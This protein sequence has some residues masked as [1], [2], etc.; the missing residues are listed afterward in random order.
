VTFSVVGPSVSLSCC[1]V[2]VKR[3]AGRNGA[4]VAVTILG[5]IVTSTSL[6]GIPV[7]AAAARALASNGA[8]A[9]VV[10]WE[11]R[12]A[13]M[14]V[15]G[16]NGTVERQPE[17]GGQLRRNADGAGRTGVG[18]M[19]LDGVGHRTKDRIRRADLRAVIRSARADP[20]PC[21]K[22]GLAGSARF[23]R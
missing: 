4:P 10:V 9:S 13:P 15:V 8:R 17:R 12:P 11:Y 5:R 21:R 22:T 19:K 23:Q 16:D 3:S 20:S 7:A 18:E 14:V 1:G 2:S 6:A